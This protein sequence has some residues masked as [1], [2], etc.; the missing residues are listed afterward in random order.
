MK[1]ISAKIKISKKKDRILSLLNKFDNISIFPS[2]KNFQIELFLEDSKIKNSLLDKI[3]KEFDDFECSEI[4]RRDWVV[5]NRKDDKGVRSELFF[6]SQGLSNKKKE[7]KK[8]KLV[9]P[10]NN[11]FGTGSHASTYL[12]IRSIEYL[13]K[14][15]KFFKICDLGTGSGILSFVL[16]KITKQNII[17]I[18]IDPLTKKCFL[19]NIKNNF[20]KRNFFIINNGLKCNYLRNKE[21]DLIVSNMLCNAQ[22]KIV[23]DCYKCLKVKGRVIISGILV[24][25]MNDIIS[26]FKKFNLNLEKKIYSSNWVALIFIK[27]G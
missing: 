3:K 19:E 14:K 13:T 10:A 27:S 18:D 25:Q 22:K 17:S 20:I 9:I 16:F 21:F 26:Y 11:A 7:N 24:E 5:Q 15:K 8:Y 2:D 6:I 23:K 12:S 1:K 4:K